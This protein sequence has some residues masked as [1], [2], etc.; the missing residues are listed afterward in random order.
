M[1]KHITEEETQIITRKCQENLNLLVIC[2][3][4]EK[5]IITYNMHQIGIHFKSGRPIKFLHENWHKHF[6]E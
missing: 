6:Q 4:K 3:R 2:A 5:N 1:N